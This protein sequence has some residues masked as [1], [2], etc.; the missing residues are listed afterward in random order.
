M[1]AMMMMTMTNNI[2]EEIQ[3]RLSLVDIGCFFLYFFNDH[4]AISDITNIVFFSL[5]YELHGGRYLSIVLTT[6][7]PTYHST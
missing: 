4:I 7:S 1:K 3:S 2:R 5:L 6:V